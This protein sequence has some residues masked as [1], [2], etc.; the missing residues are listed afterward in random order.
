MKLHTILDLTYNPKVQAPKCPDCGEEQTMHSIRE[1]LLRA[2]R[3]LSGRHSIWK[4]RHAVRK[5]RSCGKYNTDVI[6]FRFG[7][8]SVTKDLAKA[9]FDDLATASTVRSVADRYGLSWDDNKEN[10]NSQQSIK[11]KFILYYLLII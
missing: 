3:I 11:I 9:V 1:T 2:P 7:K 5:C 8:T 4:V 10:I 6:P